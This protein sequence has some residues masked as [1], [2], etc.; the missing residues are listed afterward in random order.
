MKK[1]ALREAPGA[2]GFGGSTQSGSSGGQ[3]CSQSTKG[4]QQVT[5]AAHCVSPR[6]HFTRSALSK[7]ESALPSLAASAWQASGV[8][9]VSSKVASR[10]PPTPSAS[11]VGNGLPAP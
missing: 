2:T 5:R 3:A 1:P 8:A 4:S 6:S 7:L 11:G 10:V 9:S